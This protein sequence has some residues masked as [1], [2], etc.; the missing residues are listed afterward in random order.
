VTPEPCPFCGYVGVTVREGSTFRWRHAS[1]NLCGAQGAEIR[2]QTMGAGTP[3]D[4]EEGATRHAI[5]E[6]NKRT[7]TVQQGEG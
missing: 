7:P 2:I 1:C 3:D 5:S 6:W 4:W